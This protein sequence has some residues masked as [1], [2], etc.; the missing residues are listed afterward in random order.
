[1]ER[2]LPDSLAALVGPFSCTEYLS[3]TLITPTAQWEY[4]KDLYQ[5][6]CK[7]SS[8]RHWMEFKGERKLILLVPRA[9]KL[10][11]ENSVLKNDA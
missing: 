9:W 1:M 10:E 4:Q 5:H 6:L 3:F 8:T 11:E 7:V 2:E